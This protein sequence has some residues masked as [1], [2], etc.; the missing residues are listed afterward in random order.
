MI[1]R[2]TPCFPVLTTTGVGLLPLYLWGLYLH[3]FGTVGSGP[4]FTHLRINPLFSLLVDI[5]LPR[6]PNANL[7]ASS[8]KR[9]SESNEW[10]RV[11]IQRSNS[12]RKCR[13]GWKEVL[14][15]LKRKGVE[16]EAD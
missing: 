16:I 4:G 5:I 1:G 3:S 14:G 10:P 8:I 2:G 12:T 6:L 9:A 13:E 7:K 11:V 15:G